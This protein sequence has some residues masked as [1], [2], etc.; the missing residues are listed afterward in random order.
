MHTAKFKEECDWLYLCHVPA[1][2]MVTVSREIN[3][4]ARQGP[5]QMSTAV[6]VWVPEADGLSPMGTAWCR[7]ITGRRVV[8]LRK[9]RVG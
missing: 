4:S 9:G 8:Y 6:C 1:P 5:G 3:D 7:F 2:K